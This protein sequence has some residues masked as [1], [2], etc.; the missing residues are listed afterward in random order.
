MTCGYKQMHSKEID[1]E[2]TDFMKITG[3]ILQN[4]KSRSNEIYKNNMLR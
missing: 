1:E 2:I 3:K 4:I